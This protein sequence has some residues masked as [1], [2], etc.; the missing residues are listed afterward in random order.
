MDVDVILVNVAE[1]SFLLRVP[2]HSVSGVQASIIL[3]SEFDGKQCSF[4]MMVSSTSLTAVAGPDR[5]VTTKSFSEDP[6]D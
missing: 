4:E 5:N 3:A 1:N 2:S 6:I